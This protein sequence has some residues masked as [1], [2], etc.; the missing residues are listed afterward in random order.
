MNWLGRQ[1]SNL[2]VPIPKT[3]ALPL[4]YAPSPPTFERE[5]YRLCGRWALPILRRALQL[6]L[7]RHPQTQAPCLGIP[8]VRHHHRA[9]YRYTQ[10]PPKGRPIRCHK[11]S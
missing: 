6:R 5:M 4:G 1:D 3:G 7:V 9:V 11:G 10:Y 2:R 8:M